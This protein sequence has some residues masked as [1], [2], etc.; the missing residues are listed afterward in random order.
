MIPK[1]DINTPVTKFQADGNAAGVNRVTQ[2]VTMGRNVS[3]FVTRNESA[4]DLQGV[5]EGL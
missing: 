3:V 4:R 5:V 1:H 2:T